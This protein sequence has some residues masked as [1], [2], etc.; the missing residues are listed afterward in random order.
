[1]TSQ[2]Q[3]NQRVAKT[4]SIQVKTVLR[5]LGVKYNPG[6]SFWTE[7]AGELD[8]LYFD[9]KQAYRKAIQRC[10]PDRAGGSVQ[11]ATTLNHQWQFLKTQFTK[12]LGKL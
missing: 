3:S 5:L 11:A 6:Y 12:R 8:V 9:A 4:G 1:M 10:H 7:N 2:I